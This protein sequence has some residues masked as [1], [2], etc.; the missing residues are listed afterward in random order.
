MNNERNAFKAGLFIVIS[1]LLILAVIVGIQGL[2]QLIEPK[3]VRTVSF[4]LTDD[5]GGL[6]VGDDVRVGGLKVGIV[7]SRE[8]ESNEQTDKQPRILIKFDIPQRL[9]LREGARVG[10][11]NTVTGSSWLNFDN[12][13][14]GQVVAADTLLQGRAG[15]MTQLIATASELAPELKSIAHDIR[16]ITLPKVH[17]TADSATSVMTDVKGRLDGIVERYTLVTTR[18]ADTL[19]N[20]RDILGDTKSDIRGTLSNLNSATGTIKEK[21]PPVL[22]KV[23][24]VLAKVS[25]SIDNAQGALKDLSST[26]Q[27]AKDLSAEARSIVARNRTRIDELVASAKTASDNLKFATTE[28]RHSPWRLLYKPRPN[29]MGNL[30]LFDAAR[31]FAEGAND[32]SDAATALRDALKDPKADPQLL[33]KLIDQLDHSFGE[34][35]TV[36][37][38][39]WKRVK[40]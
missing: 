34:F 14:T 7:R 22:E 27:N 30:N 3:Q 20:L 37:S 40:D 12:L 31:E 1:I 9:I 35:Q 39:L 13:G 28:I 38:A 29:E 26:M 6:R 18:L 11:Q 2:G 23:D 25:T 32:M 19:T 8:I 36:E 10:V 4:T 17:A 15:A 5:V 21:L 33:Q 16:T 24:G